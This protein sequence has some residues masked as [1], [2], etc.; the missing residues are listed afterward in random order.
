MADGISEAERT[1]HGIGRGTRDAIIWT[2]AIQATIALAS[3]LW[4]ARWAL[5]GRREEKRTEKEEEDKD[6]RRRT[7]T[8]GGGQGQEEEDK[9]KRRRKRADEEDSRRMEEM[10][11]KVVERVNAALRQFED[12]L[13]TIRYVH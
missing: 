2:G 9:D 7:R 8:R 12:V 11:G 3:L 1:Q 13:I 10:E 6:K 5:R 4:T